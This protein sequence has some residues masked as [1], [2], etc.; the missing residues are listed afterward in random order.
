[1]EQIRIGNSDMVVSRMGVGTMAWSNSK[2]WGYGADLGRQDVEAAYKVSAANGPVLFDSAEIYGFGQSE[3]ILG[4]L[5]QGNQKPLYVATK[6]APMPWR[7]NR[8]GVMKAID[9]S[10]DR[11]GVKQI[12]LYQVHFPGGWL[13]IERLMNALAGAVEAGKIRHIGVSNY[14]ADQMNR[15]QSALANRGLSLVSNQV[16]YSLINR[17]VEFNNVFERCREL[18]V[19]LIAYSPLGRGI[20]SGKYSPGKSTTDMRRHY[21]QFKD[22]KLASFRPLID[23]LREIG[24]A[25]GDKSPAQVSLNWLARQPGIL[26]IP[27]AKSEQQA[28]DNAAAITW[29]M[30]E[31][32]ASQLSQISASLN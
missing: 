3:R 31:E 15:A 28:Q 29:Q 30:S 20:L 21:G 26:P 12:D 2:R 14:S 10:L 27:G 1:M 5:I 13:K 18:G 19:T 16:E 4:A 22:K 8:R 25:H 6:Y 32:E 9:K 23:A 24:Q 11:L 17:E 7:F